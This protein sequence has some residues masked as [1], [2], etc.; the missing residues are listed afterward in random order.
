MLPKAT[1][2]RRIIH[3]LAISTQPLLARVIRTYG[4]C[5]EVDVGEG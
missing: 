2:V 3:G 5:S 1:G 4:M